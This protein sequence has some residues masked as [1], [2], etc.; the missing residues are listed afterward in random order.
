MLAENPDEP[1]QHQQ[2]RFTTFVPEFKARKKQLS[3][4][5]KTGTALIARKHRSSRDVKNALDEL[6]GLW[7]HLEENRLAK[8][9]ELEYRNGMEAFH[10]AVKNAS[11][12]ISEKSIALR[13]EAP[14]NRDVAAMKNLHKKIANSERELIPIQQMIESV[15]QRGQPMKAQYPAEE[16]LITAKESDLQAKA[17]Q[18]QQ[19][20]SSKRSELEG[21]VSQALFE[22]ALGELAEW[23]DRTMAALQENP[24]VAD[25]KAA[26]ELR[27]L[28]GVVCD[29][30][31]AHEPEYDYVLELAK[32]SVK[33]N[34]AFQEEAN[35]LLGDLEV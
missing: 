34:P 5:Q 3:E 6:L 27:R 33:A 11:D 18:L 10:D 1:L 19:Y 8:E 17:N 9:R 20:L 28:H 24:D 7:R 23:N 12:Y 29:D 13:I 26:A 16:P 2:K 32:K 25:Q 4:L 30:I 31:R 22:G 35:Q 14:V 21:D 15:R